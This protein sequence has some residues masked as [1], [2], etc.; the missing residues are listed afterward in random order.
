VAAST[1]TGTPQPAR[2][3]LSRIE[4]LAMLAQ[5]LE[6]VY[7]DAAFDYLPKGADR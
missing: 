1:G 2:T 6:Q 5:D 4:P 3:R 7:R